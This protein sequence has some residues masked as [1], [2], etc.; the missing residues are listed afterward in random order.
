MASSTMPINKVII[1]RCRWQKKKKITIM[2]NIVSPHQC[3]T[4]GVDRVGQVID[5]TLI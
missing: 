4:D 5:L 1:V 3:V 2:S